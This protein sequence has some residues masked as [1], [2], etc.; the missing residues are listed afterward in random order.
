MSHSSYGWMDRSINRFLA[1]SLVRCCGSL[2]ENWRA[3]FVLGAV[4][5]CQRERNWRDRG[6]C[7]SGIGD[8]EDH[9][10]SRCDCGEE[11]EEKRTRT[12]T[13]TRQELDDESRARAHNVAAMDWSPS[14]RSC[15]QNIAP[16]DRPARPAIRSTSPT[17]RRGPWRQRAPES[18][19]DA[20]SLFSRHWLPSMCQTRHL[21]LWLSV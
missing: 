9:G 7:W 12:R 6:V 21:C 18:V 16:W 1:N 5:E 14:E 15:W 11:K 8:R 2:E 19:S 17:S 10:V 4:E 13:R 20:G 3:F